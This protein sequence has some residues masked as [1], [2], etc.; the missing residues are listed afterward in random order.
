MMASESDIGL[1]VGIL[2]NNVQLWH[3]KILST[4]P[5]NVGVMFNIDSFRL[6]ML[7]NSLGQSEGFGF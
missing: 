1:N 5:N 6:T 2:C 3:D 4:S 7:S